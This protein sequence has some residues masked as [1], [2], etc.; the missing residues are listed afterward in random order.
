MQ[1]FESSLAASATG[2]MSGAV[3]PLS[4]EVRTLFTA[5]SIESMALPRSALSVWSPIFFRLASIW[6]SAFRAS[7][8]LLPAWDTA[9]WRSF[10]P[11]VMATAVLAQSM[12][13]E[14]ASH[15]VR[16]GRTRAAATA[17]AAMRCF[18]WSGF[19]AGPPKS[20]DT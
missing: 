7:W 3:L 9:C 18:G 2:W 1:T 15:A 13:V 6:S 11:S 8:G 19:T 4:T 12:A 20:S 17:T 10:A 16:A 5:A 14:M